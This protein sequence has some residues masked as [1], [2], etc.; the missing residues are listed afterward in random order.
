MKVWVDY[1]DHGGVSG[2]SAEPIDG[3]AAFEVKG[4]EGKVLVDREELRA[5]L[6]VNGDCAWPTCGFR[7]GR[8]YDVGVPNQ[9]HSG[10][11]PLREDA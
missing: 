1:G 4:T 8:W 9:P 2:V 5:A 11:C 3:R 10:T 6:E 7:D